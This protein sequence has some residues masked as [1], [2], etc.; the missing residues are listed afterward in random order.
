VATQAAG[1]PAEASNW[2]EVRRRAE[3]GGSGYVRQDDNRFQDGTRNIGGGGQEAPR[4]S[5]EYRGAALTAANTEAATA[6]AAMV[7][8]TSSRYHSILS[9]DL[10]KERG[11]YWLIRLL[12]NKMYLMSAYSFI[13]L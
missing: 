1:C 6:G 7:A 10:H 12:H 13:E 11:N 3:T 5:R 8:A 2:Q 9:I 4:Y